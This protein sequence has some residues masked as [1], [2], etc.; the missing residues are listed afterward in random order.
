MV[1]SI[2]VPGRGSIGSLGTAHCSRAFGTPCTVGIPGPQEKAGGGAGRVESGRLSQAGFITFI[3]P[4]PALP[5]LTQLSTRVTKALVFT[6]IYKIDGPHPLPPV[7]LG[8]RITWAVCSKDGGR[9]PPA[10]PESECL[11]LEQG[12]WTFLKFSKCDSSTAT[13]KT[14]IRIHV[15]TPPE[16]P[17]EV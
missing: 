2:Q 17:G 15:Y 10:S 16:T 13:G 9:A 3:L 12:N 4:P 14:H 1:G 6:V 7:S 8:I 5:I 11:G